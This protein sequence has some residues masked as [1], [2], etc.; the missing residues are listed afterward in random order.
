MKQI[1]L[2]TLLSFVSVCHAQTEFA[3]KPLFDL[4]TPQDE[5]ACMLF[6]EGAVR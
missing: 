4:N 5:I 3:I 6:D 1:I 2:Y